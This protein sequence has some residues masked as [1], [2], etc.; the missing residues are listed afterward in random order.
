MTMIK[1]FMNGGLIIIS[2]L[3]VSLNFKHSLLAHCIAHVHS[4]HAS[5]VTNGDK[6]ECCCVRCVLFAKHSPEEVMYVS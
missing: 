5:L 1:I 2:Y 4:T 3:L 6:N